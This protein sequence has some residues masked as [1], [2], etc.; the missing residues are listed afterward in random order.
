MYGLIPRSFHH[1]FQLIRSH[2]NAGYRITASYLEIY[3]EQ[4]YTYI[5]YYVSG[6][7]KLPFLFSSFGFVFTIFLWT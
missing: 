6:Y 5:L 3:N 7:S 4:V 2:P 1:M